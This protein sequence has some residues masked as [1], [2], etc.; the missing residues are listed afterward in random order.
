MPLFP[1]KV[2][3]WMRTIPFED[4]NESLYILLSDIFAMD[5]F[6]LLVLDNLD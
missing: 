1:M 6:F 5:I 2:D 3:Y 4:M